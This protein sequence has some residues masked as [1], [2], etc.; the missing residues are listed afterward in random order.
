MPSSFNQSARNALVKVDTAKGVSYG[1]FSS[2]SASF[3]GPWP[4]NKRKGPLAEE[5]VR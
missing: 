2:R 4:S 5:A 3:D 1:H